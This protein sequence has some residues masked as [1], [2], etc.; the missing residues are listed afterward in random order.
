MI[1]MDHRQR[2]DPLSKPERKI[3]F[4][5]IV[6]TMISKKLSDLITIPQPVHCLS[7][8]ITLMGSISRTELL[9]F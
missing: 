5:S 6:E 9:Y 1:K 7:F 2:N 8:H 3:L 4:F